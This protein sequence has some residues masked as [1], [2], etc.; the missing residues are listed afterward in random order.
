MPFGRFFDTGIITLPVNEI[1]I[2]S[3]NIS[4]PVQVYIVTTVSDADWAFIVML[5]SLEKGF[6]EM[7]GRMHLDSPVTSSKL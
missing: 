2:C 4:S 7:S 1:G 6:G 3:R 5:M